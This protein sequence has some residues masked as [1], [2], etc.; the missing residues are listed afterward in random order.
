MASFETITPIDDS[1]LLTRE[2]HTDRDVDAALSRASKTFS[3]WRS[4]P[5]ARRIEIL[6][7]AVAAFVEKK[8]S[9]AAEIT[10]QIG[11]PIA[12]SGGEVAGFETRARTMLRLAPEALQPFIPSTLEGF[13]RSIK[14]TPL[15][16][17]A[18]LAPW[19]YP[20]L[21]AVNAIIPALAAGNVVVLKHSDQTPLAA[22]RM[23]EAFRAVGLPAGDTVIG[24]DVWIGSE[25]IIMPGPA[26]ALRLQPVPPD[27]HHPGREEADAVGQRL[28]R[29]GRRR[30]GHAET[31]D[32][33][34]L[35]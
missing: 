19:N 11:R 21:T 6:E 28:Q 20:F 30:R 14:R 3:V 2:R 32:Q 8:D 33:G 24:N 13:D 35:A 25:A 18:V 1:V 10:S 4:W 9:I 31:P 15:G 29:Q 26:L 5:L 23:D 34:R 17:V 7:K 27:R 12:Y 22:E 16:V